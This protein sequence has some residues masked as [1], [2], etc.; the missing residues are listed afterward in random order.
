[1]SRLVKLVKAGTVTTKERQHF[2][3]KTKEGGVLYIKEALCCHSRVSL[4]SK[5]DRGELVSVAEG[6]EVR[7]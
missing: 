2:F 4:G 3:R 5:S 1:M 7:G 6:Q